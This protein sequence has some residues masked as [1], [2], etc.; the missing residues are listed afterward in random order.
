MESCQRV[1]SCVGSPLW[2]VSRTVSSG[3]QALFTGDI[4][5]HLAWIENK[6]FNRQTAEH[7]SIYTEKKLTGTSYGT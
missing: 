5:L 1:S 3:R 7:H 2:V 6:V 4:V